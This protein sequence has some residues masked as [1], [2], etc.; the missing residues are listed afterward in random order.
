MRIA[1]ISLTFLSLTAGC[2]SSLLDTRMVRQFTMEQRVVTTFADALKEDNEPAL[3]RAVSSRFEQKALRSETAFRDLEIVSLPRTDLTVVETEVVDDVTRRLV[4][5]DEDEEKFQMKLVRD[6][7]KDCWVVDDVITRQQQKGTRSARSCTEVMDLLL[8]LREFLETWKQGDRD[9]MLSVLDPEMRSSLE[10]LPE[11]WMHQLAGRITSEYEVAMARRPEAQLNGDDATVKLPAKTGFLMVKVQRID[12]RWL[13]SN[14]ELISRRDKDH[15]GS[16]GRQA[17]AMIAVTTFL[18]SYNANDLATLE[19][20]TD[21]EFFQGA[22]QYSDLSMIPMPSHDNAP[23]DFEIK[24]YGDQL[25]VMIPGK[26]NM[27]RLDLMSV[28]DAGASGRKLDKVGSKTDIDAFVVREVTL[29]DRQTM[30]QRNL[31]SAFT[32]PARASLFMTALQQRDLQ[33]LRA[34]STQSLSQGTWHRLKDAH[35][36]LLR[37]PDVPVGEMQHQGSRVRGQNTELD[38]VTD[39]GQVFSIILTDENGD[40]KVDDVQ[41][42]NSMAEVVSLKNQVSLAVPILECALAWQQGSLS[43]VQEVSSLQFNRLVWSNVDELPVGYID[44][45]DLLSLPVSR[46]QMTE[47]SAIAVLK[48]G[49]GQSANVRLVPEHGRW[50]IDDISFQN[51]AGQVVDIRSTMRKEIAQ[52]FLESPSGVI[53]RA[54]HLVSEPQEIRSQMSYTIGSNPGGNDIRRPGNLTMPSARTSPTRQASFTLETEHE[55][56]AVSGRDGSLY[57]GPGAARLARTGR[58]SETDPHT[59]GIPDELKMMD[60]APPAAE[61]MHAIHETS[62]PMA[63]EEVK[64]LR[65]ANDDVVAEEIN[66]VVYYR[67]SGKTSTKSTEPSQPPA[68][69]PESTQLKSSAAVQP[70]NHPID[71]SLE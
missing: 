68:T 43:E 13:I 50:L 65:K 51:S 47:D 8:T 64:Q 66:G 32:G 63:E 62:V 12:D 59:S 52:R 9:A 49:E 3:R 41:Y 45:P 48:A 60:V 57:F 67:P 34:A 14:V 7:Q 58:A 27:Y 38:F 29:Y 24:A 56:P 23:D 16:I 20:A 18:K 44:I 15:P 46:Y 61:A 25:T 28:A 2:M 39:N 5:M 11:P 55:P 17:R 70:S 26:E 22:L 10:I 1:I 37:I 6:S 54:G 53:Q 33:M 36:S 71:I 35:A 30:Q 4:V 42:P 19:K 69:T 31:S 21:H 40:L